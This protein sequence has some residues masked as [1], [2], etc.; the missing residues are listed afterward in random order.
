MHDYFYFV[1]TRIH[2][3]IGGFLQRICPI[4]YHVDPLD[5]CE[6]TEHFGEAF[7]NHEENWKNKVQRW[8]EALIEAGSIS[9]WHINE[10]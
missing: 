1:Q 10:G 9:G 8:K 2:K 7:T 3:I 4:F 5:V 6:Q